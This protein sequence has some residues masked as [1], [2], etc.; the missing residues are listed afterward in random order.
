MPAFPVGT[1][2]NGLS[3]FFRYAKEIPGGVVTDQFMKG[4]M[5]NHYGHITEPFIEVI[6]PYFAVPKRVVTKGNERHLWAVVIGYEI[7]EGTFV[8]FGRFGT[9]KVTGG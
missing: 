9:G 1:L 6:A 3:V 4:T 7:R 5:P 2:V 8:A